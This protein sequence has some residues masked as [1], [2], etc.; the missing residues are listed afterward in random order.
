MPVV[1]GARVPHGESD[2]LAT[3]RT[4]WRGLAEGEQQ[5]FALMG[6]GCVLVLLAVLLDVYRVMS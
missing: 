2:W 5:G 6:A 4:W 1:R 3:V